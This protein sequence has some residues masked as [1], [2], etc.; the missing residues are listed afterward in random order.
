MPCSQFTNGDGDASDR[1]IVLYTWLPDPATNQPPRGY[2]RIFAPPDDP[3]HGREVFTRAS[4]SGN[5]NEGYLACEYGVEYGVNGNPLLGAPNQIP[6]IWVW[7]LSGFLNFNPNP[8]ATPTQQIF[9]A[10]PPAAMILPGG[11]LPLLPIVD[12]GFRPHVAA[13]VLNSLQRQFLM[14]EHHEFANYGADLTGDGDALDYL[15]NR[16]IITPPPHTT[17]CNVRVGHPQPNCPNPPP[18]DVLLNGPAPP[19]SDQMIG[20]TANL[21][22]TMDEVAGLP[23][24]DNGLVSPFGTF[25]GDDA[26]RMHAQYPGVLAFSRFEPPQV[27]VA[28]ER[29][30]QTCNDENLGFSLPAMGP[31]ATMFLGPH[32]RGLYPSI[33]GNTMAY[34]TRE[35]APNVNQDLDGDGAITHT[36]VQRMR[37]N[38][39]DGTQAPPAL[40]GCGYGASI[41]T[42]P[43]FSVGG[44]P[45]SSVTAFLTPEFCVYDA[46]NTSGACNLM[47]PFYML[48]GPCTLPPATSWLH[49]CQ[50]GTLNQN[51]CPTIPAGYQDGDLCD[52]VV[53]VEVR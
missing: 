15:W 31:G 32:N 10:P 27:A 42:N 34:T 23:F 39:T 2:T 49:A 16:W 40:A 52:I 22:T 5:D 8:V 7:D 3:N 19:L 17:T 44:T 9:S 35:F 33:S 1:V 24:M 25:F 43:A 37:F 46:S 6:T 18:H 45:A 12:G 13:R 28:T 53:R 11:V 14:F 30:A 21:T 26:I 48:L 38:P 41:E 4:L 50:T 29:E 51:S 47:C 36:V 20:P